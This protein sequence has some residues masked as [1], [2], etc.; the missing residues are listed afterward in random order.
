MFKLLRNFSRL[1]VIQILR[2]FFILSLSFQKIGG[3]YL[4]I[5]SSIERFL[6]FFCISRILIINDLRIIIISIKFLSLLFLLLSYEP[7]ILLRRLFLFLS[8]F[9]IY[10]SL[11]FFFIVYHSPNLLFRNFLGFLILRFCLAI[12]KLT[13]VPLFFLIF[14]LM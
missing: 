1:L 13:L 12:S 14:I 10:N 7:P 5:L 9:L 8:F 11:L 4:S 2:I 6:L 3:L